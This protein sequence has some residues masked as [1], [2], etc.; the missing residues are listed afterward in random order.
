MATDLAALLLRDI[1]ATFRRQKELAER[2]IAQLDDRDF[3]RTIDPESNSVAILVKHVAGNL[4]SRWTD[5][6]TTDGEKPDRDRDDEFVL[7][8]ADDRASLMRRWE[9]GWAAL[10]TTLDTLRPE[11]LTRTV[12]LRGEELPALS[13][14]NRALAHIAQHAGQIVLLAKHLR[15]DSWQTLSIPRRRP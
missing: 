2:A 4:R 11:D 10:F 6:L 14:M 1:A 13:A 9:D 15:A 8:P 7:S 5:F 3:A 12:R